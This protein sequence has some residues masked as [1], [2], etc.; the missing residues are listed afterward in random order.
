MIQSVKSMLAV[1]GNA[2]RYALTVSFGGSYQSNVDFMKGETSFFLHLWGKSQQSHPH[3]VKNNESGIVWFTNSAKLWVSD[4]SV[5]MWKYESKGS[6]LLQPSIMPKRVIDPP[7]HHVSVT[8]CLAEVWKAFSLRRCSTS[9]GRQFYG[10][11]LQ[12][13]MSSWV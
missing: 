2:H 9:G 12:W 5:V 10:V 3:I 13:L 1:G 6:S 7:I 8:F 4:V 11:T